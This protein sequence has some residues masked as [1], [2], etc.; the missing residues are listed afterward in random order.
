MNYLIVGASSGLG[1]DLTT[2]L[3]KRKNELII[4][5]RDMKDLEALKQ[6]LNIK[7]NVDIKCFQVDLTK[8]DQVEIFL[9]RE[10]E[11]IK[12]LD[13]MLL[14]VGMMIENDSFTNKNLKSN[15]IINANLSLVTYFI[16]KVYPIFKEKN[17]GAIVGFGSV[18]SLLGREVNSSYAAAKRGLD[19][20]FE[21][22][23]ITSLANN[24]NIQYYILGYLNTS[25]SDGKKLVLPKGS[26][27]ILAEKVINNLNKKNKKF[28]FPFWWRF[29]SLIIL[30]TPFFI[31]KF[32]IKLKNL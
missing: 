15:D 26:T 27:E 21:S 3:A 30:F 12:S 20:I 10:A 17:N 6:D 24:I 2:A 13:G 4:V 8:I 19:S 22:L 25:L 28:Y 31:I 1:R 29:I 16:N 5:S 9:E 23:A 32:F 18:S 7:Y 14:P 11:L